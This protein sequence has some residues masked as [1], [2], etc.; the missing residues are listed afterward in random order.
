MEV[1]TPLITDLE[2]AEPIEPGQRALHDPP[3][4]PEALARFD[5]TSGNPRHDPTPTQRLAAAAVVVPF[6]CV[7]RLGASTWTA[8]LS[9]WQ[10]ER[11][12]GIHGGFQHL[13]VVDIGCRLDDGERNPVAVNDDMA[14]VA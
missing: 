4:P 1:G 12:D 14:L 9:P 13:A 8:T 11:R 5:A 3:I 2:A 6:V 7:Q 10:A